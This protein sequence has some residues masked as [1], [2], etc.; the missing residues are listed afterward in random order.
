MESWGS[1]RKALF[2][3]LFATLRDVV[4]A[5]V[6]LWV[7]A[8]DP[9]GL[10]TRFE[11]ATDAVVQAIAAT[12]PPS[13]ASARIATIVT[14]RESYLTGGLAY[15]LPYERQADLIDAAVDKRAVAIFLDY[16]YLRKVDGPGGQA[17][18]ARLAQSV[19]AARRAGVPVFAGMV[20]PR[21]DLAPLRA[22]L[23]QTGTMRDVPHPADYALAQP[24]GRP[25]AAVDLFRAFCAREPL[26][27]PGCAH[28]LAATREGPPIAVTFGGHRGGDASAFLGDEEAR[29]CG[30][31][32]A[33]LLDTL[34]DGLFGRAA[35]P[36]C[37]PYLMLPAELFLDSNVDRRAA[38]AL[39][40]RIVL[41]GVGAELG[42]DKPIP[43][44]GQVPGVLMHAAALDNLLTR[45][46]AYRRWPD[47]WVGKI[48]PDDIIKL[49]AVLVA[50][51]LLSLLALRVRTHPHQ[52][53]IV[54]LA[55]AAALGL[56]PAL[57][58]IGWWLGDWTLAVALLTAALGLGFVPLFAHE[59]V[60]HAFRRHTNDPRVVGALAAAL[61]LLAV[62][63][64]F[65]VGQAGVAA[66]A[67]ALALV[68]RARRRRVP[69]PIPNPD[70][71][72]ERAPC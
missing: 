66:A 40:G 52:Q 44:I 39:T 37:T 41:I 55:L 12:Q 4:A 49:G 64:L 56:F 32:R 67:L 2:P 16:E 36:P 47:D 26:G 3:N 8:C 1:V 9:F 38:A 70:P 11:T 71:A 14:T 68:I 58:L 27:A 59:H 60:G 48:G 19:T 23:R 7:A 51:F 54:A 50:P 53:L 28:P 24:D 35:P 29:R 31:M 18:V 10:G 30:T 43:G 65:G 69:D 61:L 33:G 62:L 6:V 46:N 17:G 57:A 45:G 34:R 25:T 63:L 15:P 42:D 20:S 5:L 21:A 22:A 72:T 13:S